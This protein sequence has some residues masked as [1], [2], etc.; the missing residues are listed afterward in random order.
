MYHIVLVEDE[1]AAHDVLAQHLERYAQERGEALDLT[2]FQTARDFMACT[3]SFDLVLLDIQMPGLSGMEAAELLRSYDEA[4]P[5]IFVTDLA[6]Y[7]VRGYEVNALDFM[8]KPVSYSS[9]AMRMDRAMRCL[10]QNDTQRLVLDVKG[11]PLI[12][13]ARSLVYVELKGHNLV[14]H[15]DDGTQAQQRGSMRQLEE[16]LSSGSFLRVSSGVLINMAHVQTVQGDA[17]LMTDGARLYFSRP[18][19][20]EALETLARYLGGGNA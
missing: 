11:G 8:V 13:P 15:L 1:Q 12:V 20:K 16:T 9:F 2:W 18:R 4:T 5:I 19:R 6:Q 10:R 3:R 7:A 14:Y 17:L